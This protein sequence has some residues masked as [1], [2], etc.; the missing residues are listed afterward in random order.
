MK[1]IF[2]TAL[3]ALQ[4]LALLGQECQLAAGLPAVIGAD[5]AKN[6]LIG[7]YSVVASYPHEN[8][9]FI[10]DR[11]EMRLMVM[12]TDMDTGKTYACMYDCA[13]GSIGPVWTA[14]IDEQSW[15]EVNTF[16]GITLVHQYCQ[17]RVYLQRTKKRSL[18]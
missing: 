17:T 14:S 10:L 18:Q 6:C 16:T 13:V 1:L 2:F 15:V 3:L 5:T 8:A 4:T 11:H 7:K 9:E 12:S